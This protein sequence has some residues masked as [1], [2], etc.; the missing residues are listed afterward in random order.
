VN[1]S[2]LNISGESVLSSAHVTVLVTDANDNSPIFEQKIY[3]FSVAE[4]AKAGELI[5]KFQHFDGLKSR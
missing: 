4:D 3:E 2:I 5:G 1:F